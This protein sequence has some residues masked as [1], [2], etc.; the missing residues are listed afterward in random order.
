M[1]LIGARKFEMGRYGE[2]EVR[3]IVGFKGSLKLVFIEAV[4]LSLLWE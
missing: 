2:V 3:R 1:F 4:V